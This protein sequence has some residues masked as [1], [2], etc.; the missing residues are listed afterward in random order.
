MHAGTPR[1]RVAG[2]APPRRRRRGVAHPR[3]W[4]ARA[5]RGR[6][7]RGPWA[8]V[9]A[10]LSARPVRLLILL[11]ALALALDLGALQLSPPAYEQGE[12]S[13]WWPV[14]ENV[15]HGNG[16]LAC[17]PEYFPFCGP[18]NEVTA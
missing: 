7:A 8:S 18:T 12:T 4:P 1:A 14:V 5:G 17:F 9:A 10:R 2:G 3:S 13:H 6:A 15:A 11:V 16:Y